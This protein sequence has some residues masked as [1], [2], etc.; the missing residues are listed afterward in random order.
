M[1]TCH[2]AAVAENGGSSEGLECEERGDMRFKFLSYVDQPG[3]SF[4]GIA[5]LRSDPVT[6]EIIVG[7]ANIGGPALDGYRTSALQQYDV[8]NGNLTEEELY[9]GE[10]IRTYLESINNVDLPAP[11][12]IDFSVA[13][14]GT[15]P[16]VAAEFGDAQ[17]VMTRA[18]TR[19]RQL[20][21][22]EGRRNIYSDRIAALA[23]SP[24]ERR[25]TEHMSTYA[26][27]G[28]TAA[29]S[30]EPSDLADGVLNLASPFRVTG[31]ERL[32]RLEETERRVGSANVLL[33]NEYVDNSVRQFVNNHQDWPRARLEFEL[34][35]LL[36]FETQ[37]HE[38]GHCL[39]LRHQFAASADRDNY[40]DD[41]YLINDRFPLPD[42]ATFDVDGTPGLS[43]DEQVAYE[44]RY[45]QS[46]ANRE[47]A[48]IDRWMNTSVMEYTA[49]WYQRTIGDVG[50][51]DTAAIQYGYGDMVEVYDNRTT[52]HPRSAIN[53]ADTPRTWAKYYQGGEECSVDA[54][55]PFA[56]GGAS[57]ALL[58]AANRSA[59]SDPDLR[60]QS[61]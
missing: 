11:P 21:G 14:V 47:L 42:P 57:E 27:A 45:E 43:A 41:Y 31:Q 10:D 13:S 59:G 56:D 1:N 2:R 4:L 25:L 28:L 61:A 23:G 19:A 20:E 16:T 30:S 5:T 53:P 55:C 58:T 39:G 54:D 46:R 44:D 51:Y 50:R 34:N 6:G 26:S 36:Y 15:N 29:P 40:F 17:S 24:L 38:L 37:L 8:I 33:P 35:R 52:Q 12:R 49:N 9:T 48:G 22:P 60:A 3:T 7:D 18:M 32:N